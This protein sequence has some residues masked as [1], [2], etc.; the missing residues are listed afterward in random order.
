MKICRTKKSIP[1]LT[2]LSPVQRKRN[3]REAAKLASTHMEYGLVSVYL[4][5]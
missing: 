3:Y 2:K 5:F 1:E 4:L